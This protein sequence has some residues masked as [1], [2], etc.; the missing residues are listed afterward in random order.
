MNVNR[1]ESS[2]PDFSHK[3]HFLSLGDS[4]QKYKQHLA[5]DY[6]KEAI[7]SGK[8]PSGKPLTERELCDTLGVSRTPVREALRR[9]TSEGLVESYP[10]RGVFVASVTLEK[11]MQM[12]ELREAL[13]RATARFCAERMSSEEVWQLWNC[14]QDHNKTREKGE[15][16]ASA[17]LDLRFHVLI[18][19]GARSPMLERQAKSL[20]L[21]TRRLSQLSVYDTAE[22]LH[23]IQQHTDIYQAIRARDPEAAER[24]V[25]AHSA[26]IRKFQQERW[27]LLF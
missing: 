10:G 24:A 27:K 5:Y 6:L 3:M 13:E 15:M 25:S 2:I 23:F 7:I 22:A 19:E 18:I 17:D 21:Q 8:F 1:Q 11:A 14:I 26:T 4:P 9:L 20:L 16:G 12:H